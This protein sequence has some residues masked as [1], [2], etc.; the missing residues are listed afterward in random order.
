M[1]IKEEELQDAV[2]GVCDSWLEDHGFIVQI[3]QDTEAGASLVDAWNDWYNNDVLLPVNQAVDEALTNGG[4]DELGINDIKDICNNVLDKE[5]LL[6]PLMYQ[7]LSTGY[8]KGFKDGYE[9]CDE[10]DE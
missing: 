2:I 9:S 5:D 3:D 1:A 6:I 8:S 4:Y 7:C 10:S